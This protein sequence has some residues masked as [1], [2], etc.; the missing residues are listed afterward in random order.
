MDMI[1]VSS[2]SVAAIG[3]SKEMAVLRIAF[4]AGRVYDYY[5]VPTTTAKDFYHAASKG[6]YYS[7]FIKGH[8]NSQR[9]Q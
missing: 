9:I 1:A 8:F 6:K 2:S 3:Y 5:Q 4:R 7:T